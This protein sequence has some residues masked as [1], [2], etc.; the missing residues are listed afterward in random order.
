MKQYKVNIFVLLLIAFLFTACKQVVYS[1]NADQ[2]QK[3][4]KLLAIGNS[5][6]QDALETHLYELSQAD[7]SNIIIGNLYIGG[8]LLICT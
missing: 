6:S 1:V 8:L 2:E 3:I 5:F 4:I 7:N